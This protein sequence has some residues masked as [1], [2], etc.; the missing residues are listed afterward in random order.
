M[1]KAMIGSPAPA[2]SQPADRTIDPVNDPSRNSVNAASRALASAAAESALRPQ[3]RAD[4]CKAIRQQH[5]EKWAPKTKQEYQENCWQPIEA[6][7][8]AVFRI[9]LGL[10]Q[11]FGDQATTSIYNDEG[12]PFNPMHLR[13]WFFTCRGHF[14]TQLDNGHLSSMSYAPPRSVA[15]QMSNIVCAGAGIGPQGN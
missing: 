2:Q 4:R 13:R 14:R 12:G 11:K 5:F 3:T 9:D 8:G 15:G 6:D 10:I 7:N 1:Q